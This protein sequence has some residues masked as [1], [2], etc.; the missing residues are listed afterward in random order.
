M[1][2]AGDERSSE[3]E[4]FDTQLCGPADRAAQAQLYDLCF[5]KQ[6]GARVLAWRYDQNPGGEAVSLLTRAASGV[7]VSGYACNPRRACVRGAR[8]S[9]ACIGQTGDVMTH[10]EYRGKGIFS[11]LD[12]AAMAETGRRGWPFVLGLP[13]RKSEHIFTGKLGWAQVGHIRPWTFVLK[14]DAVSRRERMRVSRLAALA[15]PVQR[16]VGRQR[17]AA[18]RRAAEGGMTLE[19]LERFTHEVDPIFAAVAPSFALIV[20]RDAAY[21]NW[22]FLDAPSGLFSAYGVR[23]ASG[24][25]RAWFVVQLARGGSGVG[26]LVD[27]LAMDSSSAAQAFTSAFDVLDEAG[28]SIARAHAIEGSSWQTQLEHAGFLAG[29]A[30]DYKAVIAYVH[31]PEHPLGM[32][33]TK[34]ESWFFTDGDRDDELVS[35]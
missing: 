3:P 4:V 26:Y 5:E 10:P 28:C 32:V 34:P 16:L 20:R 1:Q 35:G 15:V 29:K 33:A 6:D 23:D 24:V 12:R 18:L 21:L 11:D 30:A 14:T 25:L 8:E 31:D 17:R 27:L 19:R 22:R 2:S 9:E 13:N 7:A